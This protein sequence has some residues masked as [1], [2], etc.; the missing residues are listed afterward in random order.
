[1]GMTQGY[2]PAGEQ[3]ELIALLRAA[4]E[5]G[6][7]F[8]DTAQV[9]GP[10]AN[11]E[12][13]GKALAPVRDNIVIATKFG[14]HID[15]DGQARG[16]LDSRPESVKLAAE[17]S[18]KRLGVEAIDLFYQHR[19]DPAV[20]IEE[21][22]GAVQ[23][24][25]RAGKVKHFGLSEAGAGTIRRAH[26]VQPVTA[27]QSEYSVWWRSPEAHLLPLL[28]ELGIGFVAFSPLGG[29]FLTGKI[30]AHTKFDED[31][32][33]NFMPRFT[34]EARAANRAL[35]ELLSRFALGRRVTP[36]Q[37]AL[38]WLLAKKPWIVPIPGTRSLE[39]LDENI[40]AVDIQ[41][42]PEDLSQIDR[43]LA[44]LTVH[45]ARYTAELERMTGL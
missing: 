1:M 27:V 24:L 17:G 37:V 8:F 31:D 23:D 20:P 16:D 2:G 45:G 26:A 21:V 28:E 12:L 9:Y 14:F 44:E 10:Y 32:D 30:D 22:A 34:P 6:I 38:A 11:E 3:S 33:R 13:L 43:T 19:V 25:I 39:R 15:A 7:N 5:R 42:T 18:L 41:L 4:V 29:G 36:G 40:A 35:V